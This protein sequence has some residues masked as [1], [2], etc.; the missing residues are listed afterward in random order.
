LPLDLAI[1]DPIDFLSA[2]A[3]TASVAAVAFHGLGHHEPQVFDENGLGTG[4]ISLSEALPPDRLTTP[5]IIRL[6]SHGAR[7][8][9]SDSPGSRF[10]VS[11]IAEIV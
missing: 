3:Y 1:G 10:A 4:S 9:A 6:L 5:Q 2:G 7:T 8:T 11:N